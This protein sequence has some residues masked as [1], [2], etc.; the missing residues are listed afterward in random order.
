MSLIMTIFG[1]GAIVMAGDSRTL[2]HLAPKT[3][4]QKDGTTVVEKVQGVYNADTTYKVF[5]CPNNCGIAW[6]GD[7][8][9]GK[10]SME[11]ILNSFIRKNVHADTSVVSVP[12]LLLEYMQT[13]HKSMDSSFEIAGFQHYNGDFKQRVYSVNTQGSS[14]GIDEVTARI[15]NG[16][17][18]HG[19]SSIITSLWDDVA[20]T[21]L[22]TQDKID[23]CRYSYFVTTQTLRFKQKECNVG[24]PIDIL[25]IQ[26]DGARWIDRKEPH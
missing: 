8:F 1:N 3:T 19:Y 22:T 25:L 12:K 16:I 17:K 9:D 6:C 4:K 26:P 15:S 11:T 18:V 10:E 21:Y 14:A 23:Y 20:W 2:T 5:V 24:G 13:K 7:A